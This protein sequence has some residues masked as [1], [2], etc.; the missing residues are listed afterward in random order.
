MTSVN[1]I[2]PSQLTGVLTTILSAGLVPMVWSA[3]GVGKSH[4]INNDLLGR[5]AEIAQAIAKSR[6]IEIEPGTTQ[7]WERRTG[8]YDLLDYAGL[9]YVKDG[10]QRRATSDIWPGVLV[11]AKTKDGKVWGILFLDEFVQGGREK[12]TV[13]QRLF[14][15]GRVGDYVLPGHAKAD[16][17]CELGLVLIVLAG[18]RQSDKANSVGM[19][20]QTGSR[21]LVQVGPG[22]E[23][24]ASNWSDAPHLGASV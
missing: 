4:I 19:G 24:G 9:P 6:G 8:D 22:P 14:D 11:T 12:Q 18:N 20:T 13:Q 15:E 16:P 23:V 10:V 21:V 3:P 17:N 5:F 2:T 7:V 1:H